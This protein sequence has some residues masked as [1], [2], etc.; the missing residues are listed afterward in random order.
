MPLRSH[1]VLMGLRGSGKSTLARALAHALAV[2]AI[3]LDDAVAHAAGAAGPGAAFRALGQAR[4]RDLE[5]ALL[6]EHLA[7][8]P[9]VLALG[10]GTPTAPGAATALERAARAGALVVYL[11]ATPATLRSRLAGTD[12]AARP[13]LTGAGVVEEIEAVFAARDPVYRGLAG[14]VLESDGLAPPACVEQ[15]I[16]AATG[17]AEPPGR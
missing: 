6:T 10:G 14:L 15:I 8:P 3:D 2:P 7:R 4:F 9:F 16:R 5:S 13:S 12:L 17:P 11:R 1:I